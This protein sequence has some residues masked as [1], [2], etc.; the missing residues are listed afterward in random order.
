M[1]ANPVRSEDSDG[2]DNIALVIG[3]SIAGGLVFLWCG[4]KLLKW[5]VQSF[6]D[7]KQMR[8]MQ[9]ILD[10]N[11]LQRA[12]EISLQRHLARASGAYTSRLQVTA[13]KTTARVSATAAAVSS[14]TP[15]GGDSINN[16][17]EKGIVHRQDE[18]FDD[19]IASDS[20]VILSSLHSSE[21]SY[22]DEDGNSAYS[23]DITP[24]QFELSATSRPLSHV[25]SRESL[26]EEGS[27]VSS[28][29]DIEA[30]SSG[31]VEG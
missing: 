15:S 30:R 22:V 1:A 17:K 26:M 2:K 4:H 18:K 9:S 5:S 8:G 31:G 3:G 16:I 23:S 29:V 11:Q 14:V 25:R 27:V 10:T 19:G 7:Y 13:A 20:S 28:V 21:F 24:V 6:D 12:K